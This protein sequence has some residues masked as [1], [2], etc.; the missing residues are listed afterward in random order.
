MK[1]PAPFRSPPPVELRPLWL[2]LVGIAMVV[3]CAA[4]APGDGALERGE[5][6]MAKGSVEGPLEDWMM[7]AQELRGL[8]F[9]RAVEMR[10]LIR[11]EI[12]QTIREEIEEMLPPGEVEAYR[13]AYVALGALPPGLDLVATFS[14]IYGSQM[15]GRY[16]RRE[17]ALYLLESESP[18]G[19]SRETVAVHELVHALQ[20]QHFSSAMALSEELRH[21]DDLVSALA[22]VIE[23]DATFTM[24]GAEDSDPTTERSVEAAEAFRDGMLQELSAGFGPLG[25][26]PLLIQISV[27]FPY[28][29]GTV[30]AAHR[31]VDDGN[32]GIDDLLTEAPLS[33]LELLNTQPGE[34]RPDEVEFVRLPLDALAER[35]AGKS[36]K[37]GHHNV[38][39]SL[40]MRVL[41]Q[42]YRA[43]NPR[44]LE[45][46]WRG[47][48]FV[49]VEC[50]TG[51]E[52]V[53]LTR[54]ADDAAA[55][56]FASAYRTIA[57]SIAK[58]S[59]LAGIP[60]AQQSGRVVLVTTPGM[61]EHS[62]LILESSEIRAYRSFERWYRDGC[63][64]EGQGCPAGT[65]LPLRGSRHLD[66]L[67]KIVANR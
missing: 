58:Q 28:A 67:R 39:G 52:L 14:S 36:C 33:T 42:Q 45:Q 1:H 60:R 44:S 7:R 27:I 63:F 20:D 35:V 11:S 47:D 3:A 37:V 2:W 65:E 4:A 25:E 5:R 30:L 46:R 40:T 12:A 10:P 21:N 43:S 56:D 26:A 8:R 55:R 38:A 9:V 41:L 13:D 53:W 31:Y 57:P 15:V 17:G 6:I 61:R 24:L 18:G 34:R 51:P 16:S 59:E 62:Q 23:G 49:H 66:S 19:Y 54:W 50:S 22:G 29:F 48:R 32:A 64:G